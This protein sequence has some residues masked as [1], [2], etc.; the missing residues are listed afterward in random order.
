MAKPITPAESLRIAMDSDSFPMRQ[1]YD[2]VRVM[3]FLTALAATIGVE[4]KNRYDQGETP[5]AKGDTR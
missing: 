2:L 4:I 5:P 3:A 1:T